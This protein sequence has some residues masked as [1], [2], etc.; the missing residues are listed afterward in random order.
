MA[1][2]VQDLQSWKLTVD[3]EGW[4]EYN[5]TWRIKTTNVADGPAVVLNAEGLPY[6]GSY[7]EFGND[8]DVWSFC[9]PECTIAP[10][11]DDEI[12][13]LW[14]VEQTFTNKPRKRCQE[15]AIE[16]PLNEPPDISGSFLKYT[17]EAYE[18]V[19]GNI[20]TNSANELIRGAQVERDANH[21]TVSIR[22]NQGSLGLANFASMIDCVNDTPMWGLAP[23]MV[24]LENVVWARKLYGTCSYYY[25]L[26]FEFKIDFRTFDRFIVDEG[27]RTLLSGGTAGNQEHYTKKK[28]KAGEPIRILLDGNG[29]ALGPGLSPVVLQKRLYYEQNLFL[30]GIPSTLE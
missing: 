6:V 28:D 29:R 5:A 4:R 18:D 20:I 30:L 1:A 2:K 3:E 24:K 14:T 25:T 23:R 13:D 21:P 17:K 19:Y 11:Y 7:W 26:A 15:S 16:D 9:S 8:R 12:C 10:M 27:S 22:I